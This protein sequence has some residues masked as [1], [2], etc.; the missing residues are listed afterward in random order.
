M[1]KRMGNLVR[2]KDW[3]VFK[4]FLIVRLVSIHE[5]YTYF[6]PDE[7]WQTLE[8]A[9]RM[10]FGYGYLTWEWKQGI[11]NYVYPLIFSGLFSLLKYFN[12]DYPVLLVGLLILAFFRY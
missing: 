2:M 10:T 6:V 4:I 1:Y 5:V 9:H 7:Y 11:R 8:V 3:K 12:L